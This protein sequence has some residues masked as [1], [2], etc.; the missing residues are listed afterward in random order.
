MTQNI[1]TLDAIARVGRDGSFRR[2]RHPTAAISACGSAAKPD[3]LPAEVW[4]K[5]KDHPCYSVEAHHFFA[6]MH[7]AVAPACNIQC[8]YCNRKYDCANESRPGVVSE[9]LRPEQALQKV[10]A[11]AARLPQLSVVGIAGPG[12]A[13]ADH[14]HTFA[15]CDLIS[16]K[17]PGA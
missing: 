17:L 2:G 10:F 8:H 15:T 9:K 1:I 3:E 7:V 12:D 6:R 16:A 13:L 11:V 14:R 4:E 5:V